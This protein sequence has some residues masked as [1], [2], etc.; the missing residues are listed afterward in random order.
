MQNNKTHIDLR[1][2]ETY[3]D[4][5]AYIVRNKNEYMR[6]KDTLAFSDFQMYVFLRVPNIVSSYFEHS[7]QYTRTYM[8]PYMYDTGWYNRY[9]NHVLQR[10]QI[11][12]K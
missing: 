6:L 4:E 3:S 9:V 10:K 5:L 1:V 2:A 7:L 8:R 11:W 12:E